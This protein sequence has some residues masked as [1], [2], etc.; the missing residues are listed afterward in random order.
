MPR[1]EKIRSKVFNGLLPDGE[2]RLA[3]VISNISD[4]YRCYSKLGLHLGK[5]LIRGAK[6]LLT[7]R[8][9]RTPRCGTGLNELGIV[10]DGAVAHR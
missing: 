10:G 7:L 4:T 1:L 5:I 9:S 3:I 8:G 2:G 6:Q